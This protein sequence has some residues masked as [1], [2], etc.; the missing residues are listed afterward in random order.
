VS[1]IITVYLYRFIC[2]FIVSQNSLI[3]RLCPV[4]LEYIRY[5]IDLKGLIYIRNVKD[6][7]VFQFVCIQHI[8]FNGKMRISRDFYKTL[9]IRGLWI[10]VVDDMDSSLKFI[11]EN[12]RSIRINGAGVFHGAGQSIFSGCIKFLLRDE[13]RFIMEILFRMNTGVFDATMHGE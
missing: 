2:A 1:L 10:M 8:T 11:D 5:P 6:Y 4:E 3:R 12:V 7:Q 13:N 9:Y